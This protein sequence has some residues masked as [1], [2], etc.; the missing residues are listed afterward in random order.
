MDPTDASETVTC[1]TGH[2]I[3]KPA[4]GQ[5]LWSGVSGCLFVTGVRFWSLRQHGRSTVFAAAAGLTFL[6]HPFTLPAGIT[7]W[8]RSP[9]TAELDTELRVFQRDNDAL[10]VTC[11]SSPDLSP[12]VCFFFSAAYACRASVRARADARHADMRSLE[13]CILED[14]LE[15]HAKKRWRIVRR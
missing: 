1:H 9:L 8:D 6:S 7:P 5:S 4:F 3:Q 12:L 13:T 2:Q 11:L 15:G 14:I 10:K